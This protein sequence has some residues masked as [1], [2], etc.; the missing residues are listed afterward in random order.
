MATSLDAPIQKDAPV[1]LPP[2]MEV[3]GHLWESL[4][5][6][7]DILVSQRDI[8]PVAGEATPGPSR[9]KQS[10]ARSSSSATSA[11]RPTI[12]DACVILPI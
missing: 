10:P 2:D 9:A 7:L 8:W 6:W 4:G 11:S 3:Y 12:Q 1:T 5:F